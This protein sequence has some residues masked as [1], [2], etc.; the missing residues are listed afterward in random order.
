MNEALSHMN[1]DGLI[2]FKM[3]MFKDLKC[4]GGVEGE[5]DGSLLRRAFL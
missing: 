3:R 1:N 4:D 2:K 5:D